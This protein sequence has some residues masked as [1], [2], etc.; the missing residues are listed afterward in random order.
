MAQNYIVKGFSVTTRTFPLIIPKKRKNGLPKIVLWFPQWK[1]PCR[2]FSLWRQRCSCIRI[3]LSV[4]FEC[5]RCWVLLA[6]FRNL[7]FQVYFKCHIC[8]FHEPSWGW[9][10]TARP[11]SFISTASVS[12]LSNVFYCKLNSF[13][14]FCTL[15][16]SLD[17]VSV[18]DELY[19]SLLKTLQ[20]PE[21]CQPCSVVQW[22]KIF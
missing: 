21:E 22:D 4:V 19:E 10:I 17:L 14:A 5:L 2:A 20:E 18:S 7:Y 3:C 11:S 1:G 12:V 9:N 16:D 13:P 8:F 6:A 15:P